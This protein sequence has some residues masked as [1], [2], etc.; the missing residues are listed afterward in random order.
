MTIFTHG[1]NTL[2]ALL[3]VLAQWEDVRPSA[4][5]HYTFDNKIPT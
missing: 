1:R 4:R 5:I 2:K 3:N